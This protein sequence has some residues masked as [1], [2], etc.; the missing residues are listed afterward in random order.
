MVFYPTSICVVLLQLEAVY[1]NPAKPPP[2][3]HYADS[4]AFYKEDLAM[5]N[6]SVW[7]K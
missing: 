6:K 4:I 2:H 3:P 1:H 7:L 5:M